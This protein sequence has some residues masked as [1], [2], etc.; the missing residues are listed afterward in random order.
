MVWIWNILHSIALPFLTFFSASKNSKCQF[1]KNIV[2]V[3]SFGSTGICVQYYLNT[4]FKQGGNKTTLDKAHIFWN[5]YISISKFYFLWVYSFSPFHAVDW[6]TD[7]IININILVLTHWPV[8]IH[9]FCNICCWIIW[10]EQ[11]LFRFSTYQNEAQ[12]YLQ[13]KVK[14]QE[15]LY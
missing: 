13:K 14:Y 15:D 8:V 7:Q 2:L 1:M 6:N 11:E 5:A 12:I 9:M 3:Y 10:W 4:D